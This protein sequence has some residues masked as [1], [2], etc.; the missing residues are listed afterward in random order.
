MSDLS[1]S[2][3]SYTLTPGEIEFVSRNQALLD[4]SLFDLKS[5]PNELDDASGEVCRYIFMLDLIVI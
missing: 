1:L 4:L 2:L 5:I 3:P